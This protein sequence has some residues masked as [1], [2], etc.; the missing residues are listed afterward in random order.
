MVDKLTAAESTFRE[1]QLRMSDPDVAGNST[2]FQ[3]V[4]KAAA[5]LE[6]VATTFIQH[7]DIEKQLIDAQAY[8]KD[9]QNDHEMAEFAREEIQ[10]LQG[11]LQELEAKLK[12]LLLPKDPLD[13]KNIMLEIRAGAGGDEA[14]IWTGDLY[15]MYLRYAQRRSWK[16]DLLSCT[17][18]ETGGYKEVIAE[19]SGDSVYSMLKW[20]AGVHRVQRVPATESAGRVHTSTSTV[21]VMPEVG[22]VDVV[23][24]PDDID[25]KFAR[26]SGAGGQNVNKVESAVDLFHKPT[27]IRVFCQEQRTQAQNKERA[28]SILRAKLFE[29]ELQKQQD[30][31]Y[32]N[33]KSQVGTGDRSE[34]I[35]TYNFKDSRVSDHRIKENYDLN[36]VLDGDLEDCI[37]AMVSADQQ[38]RLK[39]LADEMVVT[40]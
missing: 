1:M 18:A 38:E 30:E 16:V 15:R 12:L 22:E 2:E 33:R 32:A 8:L 35:K 23:I 17:E 31:I 29:I 11:K 6:G 24:R 10:E 4:A 36:K 39:E 25:L 19:I 28:F 13:D 9:V 20:E 14:S 21:A 34:K 26:S 7:K 5:D 37:Q 27:G 40:V 3:K